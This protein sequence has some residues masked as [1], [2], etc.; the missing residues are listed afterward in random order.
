ME[1]K[2]RT[3]ANGGLDV[4]YLG[5][6]R[7]ETVALRNA[8]SDVPINRKYA[9]AHDSAIIEAARHSAALTEYHQHYKVYDRD[10]FAQCKDGDPVVEAPVPQPDW[11]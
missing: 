3:N 6:N 1:V 5:A 11:E 9:Q 7:D 2:T 8:F 10:N 4:M